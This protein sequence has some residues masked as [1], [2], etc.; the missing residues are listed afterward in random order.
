MRLVGVDPVC[1]STRSSGSQPALRLFCGPGGGGASSWRGQFGRPSS[2]S[3]PRAA[4]LQKRTMHVSDRAARHRSGAKRSGPHLHEGR[5]DYCKLLL[6]NATRIKGAPSMLTR[7]DGMLTPL[8][9]G[10]A[11]ASLQALIP[12]SFFRVLGLPPCGPS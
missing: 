2:P 8:H 3:R 10:R 11:V 5:E 7:L 4:R 1:L 6:W 9:L 12:G